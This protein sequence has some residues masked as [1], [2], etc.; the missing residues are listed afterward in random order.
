MTLPLGPRGTI[1]SSGAPPACQGHHR[2][3][4]TAPA[5]QGYYRAFRGITDVSGALPTYQENH[6]SIRAPLI[7]QGQHRP[8]RDTIYLS[9]TPP[10][11]QRRHHRLIRGTADL[12]RGTVD[13]SVCG[14]GCVWGGGVQW[15]TVEMVVCSIRSLFSRLAG[16]FRRIASYNHIQ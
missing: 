1:M 12:S 7:C 5:Y 9:G 8:V 14:C 15:P 6:P 10:T 4:R 13:L 16:V 11:Y 2:F 3:V